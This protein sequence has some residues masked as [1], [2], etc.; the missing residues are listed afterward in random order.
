MG[1][2]EFVVLMTLALLSAVVVYLLSGGSIQVVTAY[3]GGWAVV[4][5]MRALR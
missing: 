3:V 5:V 2:L 1:L 4:A